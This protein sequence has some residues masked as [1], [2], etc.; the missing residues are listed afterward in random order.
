MAIIEHVEITVE[1]F[2]GEICIKVKLTIMRTGKACRN[3]LAH[4][5]VLRFLC[6]LLEL[7]DS[8]RCTIVSITG[9][10]QT[11]SDN[12]R[13]AITLNLTNLFMPELASVS[14]LQVFCAHDHRQTRR[15]LH[16]DTVFGNFQNGSIHRT[17][18][19]SDFDFLA[20]LQF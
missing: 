8:H 7:I 10:N 11:G 16:S 14:E 4:R 13:P 5:G 17:L 2:P 18:S 1:D 20:N 3:T 19:C 6:Q 15:E 9:V 12:N